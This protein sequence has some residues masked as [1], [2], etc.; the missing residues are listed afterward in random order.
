MPSPLGKELMQLNE[1]NDD[2]TDFLP[3]TGHRTD[4]NQSA[5]I[6]GGLNPAMTI[7]S[8]H[9]AHQSNSNGGTSI[10]PR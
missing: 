2:I 3:K 4:A 10:S 6:A 7:K 9:Q 5:F 8:V 1:V